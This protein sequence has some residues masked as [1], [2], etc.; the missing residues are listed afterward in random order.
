[1]DGLWNFTCQGQ[2]NT[3]WQAVAANGWSIAATGCGTTFPYSWYGPVQV[4]MYIQ[5]TGILTASK[6]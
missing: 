5:G 2:A 4:T 6:A 3:R 1:M